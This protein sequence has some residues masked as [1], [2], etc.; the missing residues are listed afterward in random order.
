MFLSVVALYFLVE[1][2]LWF[3]AVACVFAW[4]GATA[5]R[6]FLQQSSAFEVWHEGKLMYSGIEQWRPPHTDE[7]FFLLRQQGVELKWNPPA[8]A[9]TIGG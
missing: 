2:P 3:C 4:M 5:A 8:K 7:I 1:A 6:F 9:C